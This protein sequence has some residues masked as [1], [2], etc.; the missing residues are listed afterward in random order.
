[1]DR[2]GLKPVTFV[3]EL[4]YLESSNGGSN[5][6]HGVAMHDEHA[7]VDDIAIQGGEVDEVWMGKAA[8]PKAH[9]IR[10]PGIDNNFQVLV[11]GLL[12]VL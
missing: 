6:I 5:A 9:W 12:Q 11:P 1:M 4:V 2:A 7:K 8:D 10:V 3:L